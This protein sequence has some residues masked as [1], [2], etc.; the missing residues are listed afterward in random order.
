[1]RN[2]IMRRRYMKTR[3]GVLTLSMLC[4]A[5][6]ATGSVLMSGLLEN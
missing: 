5:L 6:F 1:M 2:K 3:A 4:S